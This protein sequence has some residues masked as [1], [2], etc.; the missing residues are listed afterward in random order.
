MS[1]TPAPAVGTGL[2]PERVDP[3]RLRPAAPRAGGAERGA[4]RARRHS[5][6]RSS[7]ASAPTSRRPTSIGSPTN[8]LRVQPLPRDRDLLAHA[9][10]PAHRPQP[11]RGRD[12]LPHRHAHGLSRATRHGSRSRRPR[13]RACCATPGTTRWRWA[14][15]TSSRRASVRTRDR[16][17]GGRSA[18]ASSATTG[19]SRATRTSGARTSSATTS[20]V[21]PPADARR[22]LPPHR[23]PRRHR[24]PLRARTRTTPRPIARSSSTSPLGAMHAPHHVAPEWVEP[25]RGRFDDGWERW[26]EETFARQVEARHRA[27]G[28]RALANARPWVQDW[29]AL[30]D[31]ERRVCSRAYQEVFA[32]FLTHTD[33]QIGR[34]VDV[35]RGDRPARQH[36]RDARV[37]QRHQRRGRPHRARSTSTASRS[38]CPRPSRR[39]SHGSTSS[40]A[41]APTT[42][43]RGVGRGRATRRCGC[44]S[45]TRGW[46]APHAADRALARRHRRARRGARPVRARDRPHADGA[47]RVRHR[48]ARRRRRRHATADRRRQPHAHVRRRRARRAH[49]TV[50]Y[51]EML[52]SRSIIY[53]RLE[54]DHRPRV[55][56]R[57]R[58]GAAPRGEP[59]LR[60]PTSGRCSTSPTT[61]PRP[62]TSPPSTPRCVARLRR[63]SGCVEAARNQVF[64]LVDG[65]VARFTAALPAAQSA[66]RRAC[67]FRPTG[68]PVP[69]DSVPRLFGGFRLTAAVD[70]PATGR[71]R[72]ALRDGRLDE[73]LR[74]LRA[75][76]AQL[77]FTL[78]RAG[79]ACR[80]VRGSTPVPAGRHLGSSC[81]YLADAGNGPS[82]TLAA[83]RRRRSRRSRSTC[84]CRCS[85]STA[86]PRSAS[87]TTAGSR[88]A[89]STRSRS[90]WNG[91]LHEVIVGSRSA[92]CRPTRVVDAAGRAQRSE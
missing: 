20:Y 17:T 45:A 75:A 80:V 72:R 33:A 77:V 35:P 52:G 83:R 79:D 78:N 51:F 31:D 4:H 81:H 34:V 29:D 87:A 82:V 16:S 19:S 62:P 50:Q 7:A 5:A 74:V 84:R 60:R 89:T 73:R 65:L 54:G 25:Y 57:R 76:T 90:A 64:P 8:G 88:C 41:S 6:S 47:R 10:L 2:T 24:D 32:G 43:T 37:R 23:G 92:R 67:V 70:V 13:C 36:A 21:D 22:R 39:T 3:G 14:S 58:R 44:G 68:S 27:R 91:V 30:S 9:G 56:G 63:R 71:G 69:D 61:S 26:R 12:G 15:G 66:P 11:P 48:R 1:P 28:H 46:A 55:A 86:A 42:T 18:S 59:R 53:R 85:G 40:A 38:R 49:A